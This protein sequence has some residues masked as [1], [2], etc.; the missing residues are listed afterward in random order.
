MLNGVAELR[1]GIWEASNFELLF[2][3]LLLT[4]VNEIITKEA[5]MLCV[6]NNYAEIL[7][8]VAEFHREIWEASN[9]VLLFDD[10]HL[11][12]VNKIIP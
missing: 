12:R 1:R 3:N 6:S 2:D 7:N 11:A 8:G 10:L 5:N 4:R 9:F